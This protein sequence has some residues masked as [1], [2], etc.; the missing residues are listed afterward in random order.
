MQSF[1]M[2]DFTLCNA[3]IHLPAIEC[4]NNEKAGKLSDATGRVPERHAFVGL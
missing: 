1:S 2:F 3:C 4:A